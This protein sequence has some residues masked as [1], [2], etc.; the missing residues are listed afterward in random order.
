MVDIFFKIFKFLQSFN[1]LI[2]KTYF[3]YKLLVALWLEQWI[4]MQKVP[5]TKLKLP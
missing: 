2:T 5:S 1:L 4:A 3:T